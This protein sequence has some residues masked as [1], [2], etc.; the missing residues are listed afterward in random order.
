VNQEE[1]IQDDPHVYLG[2]PILGNLADIHEAHKLSCTGLK[3]TATGKG[4]EKCA[5]LKTRRYK[6]REEK[7][8]RGER[9]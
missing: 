9:Q 6:G 3:T 1:N 7:P 2:T 4:E 8:L 5:G